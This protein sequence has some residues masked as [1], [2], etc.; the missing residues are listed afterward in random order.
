[1]CETNSEVV[2]ELVDFRNTLHISS[3]LKL[4]NKNGLFDKTRWIHDEKWHFDPLY[5]TML[6]KL[7]DEICF[8]CAHKS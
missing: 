7:A 8:L 1:M 5:H 2:A 6:I 3:Y 4:Q